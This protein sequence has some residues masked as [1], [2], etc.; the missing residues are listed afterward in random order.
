MPRISQLEKVSYGS[1]FQQ[2]S[3]YVFN[4]TDTKCYVSMALEICTTNGT[5]ECPIFSPSVDW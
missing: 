4:L 5:F 1:L 3:K 2:D